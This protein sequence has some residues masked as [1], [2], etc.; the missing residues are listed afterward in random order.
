[1]ISSTKHK[2][3]SMST[4]QQPKN[5]ALKSV[6]LIVSIQLSY[7]TDVVLGRLT[8]YFYFN[9]DIHDIRTVL[10]SLRSVL[11]TYP[12]RTYNSY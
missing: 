7:G 5:W 12:R 2:A 8:Y 9:D 11:Y 10:K 6:D 4:K 1:V 3:Q